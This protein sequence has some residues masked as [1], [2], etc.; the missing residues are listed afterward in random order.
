MSGG[1]RM[2][3]INI[4]DEMLCKAMKS[5]D[6][7]LLNAMPEVEE[8][9]Y[10]FSETFEQK[11]KK[12]FKREEQHRR[13]GLPIESWKRMVAVLAVVISGIFAVSMSVEAVREKLFDFIETMYETYVERQ[14]F[15]REDMTEEFVPTYPNYIPE[16]YE[17]DGEELYDNYL[18]IAYKKQDD[19]SITIC[20]EKIEDGMMISEDIEYMKEREINIQDAS[21]NIK[22]KKNGV[23]RIVWEKQGCIYMVTGKGISEEEL[24]HI[25]ES[26]E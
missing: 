24:I 17:I 8:I 19:G 16:G 13:Y 10:K 12:I 14:Y 3:R 25:C 6:E 22:Y 26:M 5:L 1:E 23:I 4:T 15:L 11:M 7:K 18:F 21:G 2:Q 9:D 20:Q